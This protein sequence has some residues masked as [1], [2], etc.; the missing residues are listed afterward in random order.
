MTGVP[1]WLRHIRVVYAEVKRKPRQW[2]V[3][4]YLKFRRV[5]VPQLEGVKK[6]KFLIARPD[7]ATPPFEVEAWLHL[8]TKSS[9]SFELSKIHS[10]AVGDVFKDV[11]TAAVLAI[12]VLQKKETNTGPATA[13]L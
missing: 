1:A 5:D 3:A 12:E 4:Y 7:F 8:E 2:G 13:A 10:L 11:K 6:A 9:I